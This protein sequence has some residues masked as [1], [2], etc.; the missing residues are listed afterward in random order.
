MDNNKYLCLSTGNIFIK[1]HVYVL[2]KKEYVTRAWGRAAKSS[3]GLQ[4][5]NSNREI[6]TTSQTQS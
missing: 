2:Y 6:A 4:L 1:T 3:A 5:L